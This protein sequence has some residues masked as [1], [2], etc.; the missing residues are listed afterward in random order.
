[1]LDLAHIGNTPVDIGDFD[2]VAESEGG[3]EIELLHTDGVT[4]TGV[5]VTVQGKHSDAVKKWNGA[6]INKMTREHQ[7][8]ARK[9]KT[10]EPKTLEELDAQNIE[11]AAVRVI[12]WRNVKQPFSQ[13]L[14]KGA[15]KRNPHWIDAI[16]RESDD[17]G[18]FTKAR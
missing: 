15:L 14:M 13:D 12:G 6:L 7:M 5:F 16:V 17:L 10:V 18:N 2:A 3:Y 1:M 11:G 9:G 4:G 8:A